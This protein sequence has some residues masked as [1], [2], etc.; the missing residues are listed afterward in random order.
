MKILTVDGDP[1][2]GDFPLIEIRGCEPENRSDA[3]E[4]IPEEMNFWIYN[5]N[6]GPQSLSG[7]RAI[8]MEVQVQAFAY[9]TN[10]EINDMTFY[11]YKLINKAVEDIV[12]C[13]FSM[14]RSGFRML[15]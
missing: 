10:D 5:D 4:L 7:P 12:D 2:K 13:Y 14:D 9:A 11:R 3:R 6:G 15:C 1:C 8:Q